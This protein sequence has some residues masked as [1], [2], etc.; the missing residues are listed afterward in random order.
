MT[1]SLYP[2]AIYSAFVRGPSTLIL[3][4]DV[5]EFNFLSICLTFQQ[6][7][8]GVAQ[9]TGCLKFTFKIINYDGTSEKRKIYVSKVQSVQSYTL[10]AKTRVKFV[11]CKVKSS[12]PSDTGVPVLIT[13]QSL[14]QDTLDE[15]KSSPTKGIPKLACVPGSNKKK[16]QKAGC[17]EVKSVSPSPLPAATTKTFTIT[18]I[19][20]GK[21]NFSSTGCG[22][23]ANVQSV[24]QIVQRPATGEVAV[25]IQLSATSTSTLS[26]SITTSTNSLTP[27]RAFLKLSPLKP[28][29]CPEIEFPITLS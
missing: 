2:Y 1:S 8:F 24:G 7:Q 12:Q 17:P 18:G 22:L 13:L 5:P 29:K 16:H 23:L 27:G 19:N 3:E 9:T 21:L 15:S 26:A 6:S 25:P 20:L 4:N 28:G 11:T 14:V 10:T